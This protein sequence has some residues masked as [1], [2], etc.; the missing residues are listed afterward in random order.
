[1]SE[2]DELL[3]G[4]RMALD[5]LR[6]EVEALQANVPGFTGSPVG[7]QPV[8]PV[9]LGWTFTD[10]P[11]ALSRNRPRLEEAWL[12]A[13]VVHNKNKPALAANQAVY[14]AVTA[15]MTSIGIPARYSMVTGSRAG[16]TVRAIRNAGWREDLGKCVPIDDG[17][18]AIEKVYKE[19]L[20]RIERWEA[21]TEKRQAQV[22]QEKANEQRK[23]FTLFRLATKYGL[24]LETATPDTLLETILNKDKFLAL[25]YGLERN[26]CDWSEGP[27]IAQAAL[28]RFVESPVVDSQVEESIRQDIQAEIDDWEGDGRIF[29]DCTWNYSRIYL[30]CED[31]SAKADLDLYKS[32][33]E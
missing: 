21:V 26:R 4:F 29:R 22:E 27:R 7:I 10:L 32:C 28:E 11:A 2:I 17:Y 13:Q 20:A 9:V 18:Q 12:K 14:E 5:S 6:R 24:E 15:F 19:S 8:E 1:M 25:A 3:G 30:L 16:R 31:D 33:F 23:Q